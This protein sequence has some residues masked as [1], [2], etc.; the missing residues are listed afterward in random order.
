MRYLGACHGG[1]RR[2]EIGWRLGHW[3]HCDNEGHGTGAGTWF[4]V[5]IVMTEFCQQTISR[6]RGE[7][8]ED[9][10]RKHEF[11]PA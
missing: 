3:L 2:A 7:A 10:A 1:R 11:S 5:M 8:S 6:L 4:L 9:V